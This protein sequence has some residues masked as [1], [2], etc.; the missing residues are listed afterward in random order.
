MWEQLC[1]VHNAVAG[2]PAGLRTGGSPGNCF[3]GY[4]VCLFLWLCSRCQHLSYSH[5]FFSVAHV[6]WSSLFDLL[7]DCQRIVWL[8]GNWIMYLF[9]RQVN[10]K[11]AWVIWK[12]NNHT[13]HLFPFFFSPWSRSS[14]LF[15]A[16]R[17]HKERMIMNW[18]TYPQRSCFKVLSSLIPQR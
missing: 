7:E 16:A 12:S 17:I 6:P 11:D 8:H 10:R 13:C 3:W 9:T 15:G 18:M 2:R 1:C 4:D 14:V 5:D